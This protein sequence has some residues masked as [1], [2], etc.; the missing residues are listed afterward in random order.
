MAG[1]FLEPHDKPSQSPIIQITQH[2]E[3]SDDDGTELVNETSMQSDLVM[4][5]LS[6]MMFDDMDASGTPDGE[7]IAKIHWSQNC[8]RSECSDSL[9]Q[10]EATEHLEKA[11]GPALLF[12]QLKQNVTVERTRIMRLITLQVESMYHSGICRNGSS[13]NFGT[14]YNLRGDRNPEISGE[15]VN[16]AYRYQSVRFL[17][18]VQ[19]GRATY[20][21]ACSEESFEYYARALE[22]R[23]MPA[24]RRAHPFS[25]H[26]ILV[27]KSVLERNQELEEGLRRLLLLEDR[28]IFRKTKV[29]FETA[30]DTKRRLQDLHSL[31]RDVL[32]RDN[33]NKRQIATIDN[34]VQDLD[35][36]WTTVKQTDGAFPIDEHDHQRIV[37]GFR[38]LKDF[39]LDRERRLK[40]RSQRVQNLI[41]LTYNLLA[42]RDSI[43][44]HSIAHDA[45]QDGAAM[46][47][48]AMVTML[49]F[50]ATFVSS[51]L[52]TNLVSLD[53][54]GDG[55]TH[56]VF[57]DL[58]WIYLVAAIPLTLVTLSIYVYWIKRRGRRERERFPRAGSTMV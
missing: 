42:N 31:F 22:G 11:D 5:D 12:G 44:S 25:I 28:S 13:V 48:I 7:E 50:P 9:M 51:F 34:L 18:N 57:S 3:R 33:N 20:L 47:T 29:T 6:F 35:R 39:C 16:L 2:E 4:E 1:I 40:S 54:G 14:H 37:D 26:L 41:A 36:L 27:F 17:Y 43:T 32:I 55:R 10:L 21:L 56:F 30:D 24:G 45:R 49:F 58:W 8:D 38:C 46:K 52:G 19:T 23:R 15:T 53:T